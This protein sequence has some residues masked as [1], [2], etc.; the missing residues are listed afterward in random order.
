VSNAYA[1]EGKSLASVTIIGSGSE[2]SSSSSNLVLSDKGLEDAVRP[3]L[4]AWF[5]GADV[6]EGWELLRIYRIPYAQPS[7]VPPGGAGTEM[8][9]G[10]TVTGASA[11]RQSM[12]V[13][14]GLFVC[15]DHRDT[16]T[17]NGAIASGVR[18]GQQVLAEL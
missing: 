7:Q 16:A 17:L 3:Q 12:Q 5:G 8:V 14:E 13:S 10:K 6:V 9:T 15:G 2:D 1:P 11:A 4:A 18:A